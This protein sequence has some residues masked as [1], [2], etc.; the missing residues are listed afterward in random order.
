MTTSLSRETM[1]T[2]AVAGW[3]ALSL[4]L[5]SCSFVAVPPMPTTARSTV[6]TRTPTSAVVSVTATV[7]LPTP[8][9]LTAS[10]SP[11]TATP[12]LPTATPTVVR[13]EA[14]VERVI[15]GDTIEVTLGGTRAIVQYLSVK[16]PPVTG[17]TDDAGARAL[18]RNRELVGGKQVV[19]ERDVTD[20]NDQG[21]LVRYV[22][23][24]DQLINATLVRE[25]YVRYVAS[26]TDRRYAGLLGYLQEEARRSGLGIW[27]NTGQASQRTPTAAA[28]TATPTVGATATPAPPVFAVKGMRYSLSPDHARLVVDLA[29]LVPDLPAQ[30]KID[31][32][33]KI[34]S[35]VVSRTIGTAPPLTPDDDIVK[36]VTIVPASNSTVE[37][38]V[39]LNTYSTW[40]YY[41]V[42]EPDRLVFDLTPIR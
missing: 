12:V 22:W 38:R 34:I 32:Q 7:A 39:E 42:R 13:T 4:L 10:P 31:Q 37:I 33:D 8:P 29:R 17:N 35:I 41:F 27:A 26:E 18:R 19:L 21:Q 15:S 25:G 30:Y 14:R 16:A 1:R 40:Q 23:I 20:R 6:S 5:M 2:I 9:A 24:G 36:R 11:P 28:A 3:L